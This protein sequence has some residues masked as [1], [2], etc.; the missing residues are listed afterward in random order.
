[1]GMTGAADNTDTEN[2][3]RVTGHEMQLTRQVGEHLVA[4]ELGR[5]GYVATP[6]AGNVPMYDL[7][8]AD[9]RG[10]AIPVQ[11]KAI[12]KGSW[13]FSADK[14]LRITRADDGFQNKEGRTV[15]INPDLICIF[16]V[17]KGRGADEFYIFPLREIQDHCDNVYKP[18]GP[19]SKN[20][21]SLHCAISPSD[22]SGF[23]DNWDLVKHAFPSP[24]PD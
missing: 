22:L 1:M 2:E 5:L 10:Y 15:L 20:P 17:L 3:M 7:L 6:F 14:F 4:A 16:V 18:R 11:V 24:P 19:G 21:D 9:V 13:Q 12:N 8:V 23:K